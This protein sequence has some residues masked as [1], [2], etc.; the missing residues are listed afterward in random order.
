M[1]FY[2]TQPWMEDDFCKVN[3]SAD[4]NGQMASRWTNVGGQADGK[5][6]GQAY[7]DLGKAGSTGQN[8]KN[9]FKTE[10]DCVALRS[11]PIDLFAVALLLYHILKIS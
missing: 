2:G 11:E 8:I 5:A 7:K 3:Y 6:G 1:T 4:I 10:Q 9:P